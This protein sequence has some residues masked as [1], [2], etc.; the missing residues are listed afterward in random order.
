ME[1]LRIIDTSLPVTVKPVVD[2]EDAA[3]PGQDQP[4]YYYLYVYVYL[5]TS[6]DSIHIGPKNYGPDRS[7]KKQRECAFRMTSA[8]V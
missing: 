4:T 1:N 5:N 7:R 6:M 2:N 3:A 8:R